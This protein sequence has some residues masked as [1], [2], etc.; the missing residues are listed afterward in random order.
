ME[1]MEKTDNMNT[2]LLQR[3]RDF[4]DA[5]PI[6]L[7]NMEI[8][9]AVSDAQNCDWNSGPVEAF[10]PGVVEEFRAVSERLGELYS[11][12]P[13]GWQRAWI[14]TCPLFKAGCGFG[15]A[16]DKLEDVRIDGE[17][18]DAE[19]FVMKEARRMFEVIETLA[20]DEG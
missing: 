7:S 1:S 17:G 10:V 5:D 14:A 11:S 12:D 19:R 18:L 4:L 6:A 16:I 20:A 13:D 15:E 2:K 8:E 3:W 9:S